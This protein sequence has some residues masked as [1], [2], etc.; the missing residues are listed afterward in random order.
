MRVA[1]LPSSDST[2]GRKTKA[3]EVSDLSEAFDSLV[4]GVEPPRERSD[5]FFGLEI[6]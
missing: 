3:P 4:R 5:D 6:L 2:P 1:L